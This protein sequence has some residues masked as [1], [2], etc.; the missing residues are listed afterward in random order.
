[1]GWNNGANSNQL[2]RPEASRLLTVA[3]ADTGRLLHRRQ[4]TLYST[5]THVLLL[6]KTAHPCQ[7]F[8]HWK[9][10]VQTL[11]TAVAAVQGTLRR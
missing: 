7:R 10:D 4:R 8:P 9:F 1:M 3:P 2:Y 6:E 5:A 11:V